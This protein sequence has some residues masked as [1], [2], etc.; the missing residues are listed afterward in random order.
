MKIYGYIGKPEFAKK[1][2]GRASF[3][4]SNNRYIKSGSLHYAV[5]NGFEGLLAKE[6]HPFYVLCIEIDPKRI[7]VNVH[8]TKTEIKFDDERMV[9]GIL[10]AAHSS[11]FRSA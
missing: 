8:P 4:S 3:S 11:G 6:A 2:P 5:V 1:N 7:D 9:Y 10:A